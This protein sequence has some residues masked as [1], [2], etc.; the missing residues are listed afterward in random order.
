LPNE[1]KKMVK[2]EKRGKEEKKLKKEVNREFLEF[3]P[4]DHVDYHEQTVEVFANIKEL[5]SRG[6]NP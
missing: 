5:P 6:L 3:F 1:E 2:E 4:W